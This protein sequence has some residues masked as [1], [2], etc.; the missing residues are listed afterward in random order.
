MKLKFTKMHGLGNDFVVIDAMNQQISLSPEQLRRLAD[1]HLGIGCDQILLVEKAEGDADF[2]YRIF[3]ADGGEVEQ[4]GNGA[5]CFVRYVHDHGMTGKK[6]VRIETLSGVVI[7][8]LEANGEVTVNMG[9]PKFDPG[10]IPF[11]ADQRAP[12][13]PLRLD[14]KEVEI[15]V[16][17]MGNPHA[18]QVVSDLDDAPVLTEGPFIEKHSRFPQRV[19]AGYMQVIDPHHIRLRVYERGAGETLACGTG[20]CAAAVAGIQRGLLESPVGVSFSTGNLFIRWE[21]ENQPVWMTG[22]AITVFD[23]EIEL[24]F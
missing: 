7:P 19:N 10:E 5:R 20:A 14:D 22:P 9:V 24:Q 18:V 8:K 23:G 12:T 4:C 16:V 3:N 21:G 15:S 2:R 13:Y 17:S 11:I 6:E 1:R